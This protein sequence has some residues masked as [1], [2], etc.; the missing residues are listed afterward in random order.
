MSEAL[1]LNAL[2]AVA[3]YAVLRS[4]AL[5]L[6]R[7]MRAVA[8]RLRLRRVLRHATGAGVV[9]LVGAESGT[10]LVKIGTTTTAVS[11]RLS[12]L[13]TGSPVRL[14]VLWTTPGGV[15]LESR[16][17]RIFAAYRR[18]GEWFDLGPD[19]V[20]AIRGALPAA[21]AKPTPDPDP[22]LV[23]YPDPG[24]RLTARQGLALE[25]LASSGPIGPAELGRRMDIN[26]SRGQEVLTQLAT[27]SIVTSLGDGTY[28]LTAPEGTDR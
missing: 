5:G 10:G 13:Q 19:A 18:H 22:V 25:V 24:P 6:R 17:H 7:R 9:Y 26:R 15:A 16:L 11:K 14:T 23:T 28:K 12:A 21:L 20:R 3:G 8:Y 2:A 27:R 4:L 1:V